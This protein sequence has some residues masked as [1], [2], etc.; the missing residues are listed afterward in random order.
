MRQKIK[1][2]LLISL[3][4]LAVLL[5]T[6]GIVLP[7]LPTTPFL[8]L[9]LGCFS[10]SSPRF[11]KMLLN[12]KWLGPPLQEWEKTHTI[13]RHI[14]YRVMILIII[15]FSASIAILSGRHGLQLM[16]VFLGLFVLLLVA[17]LKEPEDNSN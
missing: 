8:I 1:Q 9:A 2:Y 16:L 11:H 7:L 3:G 17:R 15:S 5:G 14:K 10:Q 4:C 13:R 6:I 12:N